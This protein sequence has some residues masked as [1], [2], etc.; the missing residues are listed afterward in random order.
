M[1]NMIL[2][3]FYFVPQEK[4]FYLILQ[5]SRFGFQSDFFHIH[6]L[7]IEHVVL[8]YK[9]HFLLMISGVPSLRVNS[10]GDRLVFYRVLLAVYYWCLCTL[11]HLKTVFL[12]LNTWNQILSIFVFGLVR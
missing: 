12:F 4:H 5:L 1:E 8:G 2:F 3:Y 9:L 10:F 11:K 7:Q 6:I